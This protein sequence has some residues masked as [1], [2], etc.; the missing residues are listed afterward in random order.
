MRSEELYL[1]DIIEAIDAI[2]AFIAGR[3][4]EEFTN[5]DLLRSGVLQKFSV[6]GEA[7]RRLS[8]DLKQ[9]YPNVP[10]DKMIGMRNVGVHAYFELDWN[11]IWDT[12]T[13]DIPSL[14]PLI[15]EI[16]ATEY[17]EHNLR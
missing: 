6:I 4:Q 11:I 2:G 15:V 1:V 16:L 5:D 17:P 3:S 13:E 12:A 9:R 7:S 8:D 14:R 10:W